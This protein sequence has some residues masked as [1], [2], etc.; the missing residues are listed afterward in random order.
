MA[1]EN[2]TRVRYSVKQTSKGTVQL[3]ITAEAPNAEE[4][5]S[6]LRDGISKLTGVVRDAG[7]TP[8]H[9]A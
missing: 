5:E 2:E 8:V 1:E 7:L 3:D 6:M 4:A 9:E